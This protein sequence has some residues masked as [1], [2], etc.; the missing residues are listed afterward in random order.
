MSLIR[1]SLDRLYRVCGYI[2]AIL[3]A[4]IAIL[5][6]A[7]IVGRFF[8]VLVPAA[9][10]MAGFF[11]AGSTFLALAYSFRAGSHIRVT[12]VLSVLPLKLRRFFDIL[13][14]VAGGALLAY[15][16]WYTALLVK[17]SLRFGE[18]SDGLLGIP[19]AIPQ[20]AMLFGL[21]MLT[22]AIVD[23]L[24]NLLQGN[25][26]SFEDSADVVLAKPDATTKTGH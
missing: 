12:L 23:E 15:S 26:P 9:N 6:L 19:L 25:T 13:V 10:E 11:M 17:D 2:A 20:S 22:V 7:Q 1:T 5:I 14:L 16:T 8:G 3:L 4:G 18:V 21:A 24:V